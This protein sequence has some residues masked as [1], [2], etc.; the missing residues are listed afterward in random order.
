[1]RAV[2]VAFI[3]TVVLLFLPSA[4]DRF[5]SEYA[6]EW[7]LRLVYTSIVILTAYMPD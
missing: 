6:S 4:W 7:V 3:G 5:V 1:M 2:L